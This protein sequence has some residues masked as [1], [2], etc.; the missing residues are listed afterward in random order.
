MEQKTYSNPRMQLTV[1][2]WP[3]GSKR[4]KAEFF[5]E[6]AKGKERAVR[7]TENP[8]GG[9]NKP[10]K[11]TYSLKQR[12]VDGSDGRTYIAE[13]TGYGAVSIRQSDMKHQ[14]EYITGRDDRYPA[15]IALFEEVQ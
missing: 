14:E 12:I 6:Q 9:T 7:V 2:D 8:K 10:K 5:I 15:M 11:L 4:V 1:N 3:Y 13:L